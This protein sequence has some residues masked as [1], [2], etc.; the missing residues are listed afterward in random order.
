M[1]TTIVT[2][3]CLSQDQLTE[4]VS[5]GF[6]TK[7]KWYIQNMTAN[8]FIDYA[9]IFNIERIQGDQNL[10]LT[11][12]D[13]V[14]APK[15]EVKVGVGNWNVLDANG[16]HCQQTAFFYIDEDGTAIPCKYKELPSQNGGVIPEKPAD[17]PAPMPASQTT[18]TPKPAGNQPTYMCISDVSCCVLHDYE[19]HNALDDCSDVDPIDP[20]NPDRVCMFCKHHK[21]VFVKKD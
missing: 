12:P 6:P 1:A 14:F 13:G 2:K 3:Y 20:E 4:V 7:V 5:Q 11:F 9:K 16:R 8:Q 21:D 10:N 17:M 18:L 15:S 19:V